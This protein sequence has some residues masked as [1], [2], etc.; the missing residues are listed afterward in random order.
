[1]VA[2]TVHNVLAWEPESE[3]DLRFFESIPWCA[4]ILNSPGVSAYRVDFHYRT[5]RGMD[6]VIH[7]FMFRGRGILKYNSFLADVGALRPHDPKQ[8]VEIDPGSLVSCASHLEVQSAVDI[9]KSQYPVHIDIFTLG[10]DLP[11]FPRTIHGGVIALLADG[12]CARVA[13]MHRDPANQIYTAYTNTRFIKPMIT[14]DDDGTITILVKA[15][16]SQLK[17]AEGKIVVMASFEGPGGI[18]YATAESMIIE[19]VWKGRL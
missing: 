3:A 6:P 17:S 4:R 13:H 2:V 9:S 12:L 11:G 19:N 14:S 5:E 18:V 16:I 8:S 1:M 7:G 15:Q 10:Q